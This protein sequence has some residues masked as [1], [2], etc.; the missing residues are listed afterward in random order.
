MGL[1]F[2]RSIK[3]APGIRMNL[4]GSG[5]SWSLGPRGASIGI[6]KRGTYLNTGIPGTGLYSRER[7]GGGQSAPSATRSTGT[8]QVTTTVVI[9]DDG[10]VTF[11]D[12]SG[13]PLSDKLIAA[14]KKQRGDTVRGFIQSKHRRKRWPPRVLAR[15]QSCAS[16]L[17]AEDTASRP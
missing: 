6:G 15:E 4:S 3:L 8:V 13:N 11:R 16:V 5:L 7:I 9:D 2:R 14:L 1:R 12:A 17:G 10:V